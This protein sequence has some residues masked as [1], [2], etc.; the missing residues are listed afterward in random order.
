MKQLNIFDICANRHGSNANSTEALK[1][2]DTATIRAAI[3][4]YIESQ[5]GEGATCEEIEEA[6]GLSHQT[7]SARCSELKKW[8]DVREY[9][10]RKTKSGRSAGVLF[11]PVCNFWEQED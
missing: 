2:L 8:G 11:I 4:R 1:D 10:T 3:K 7:A 9:G 5:G 6:L